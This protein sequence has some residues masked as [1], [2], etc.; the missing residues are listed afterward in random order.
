LS[1]GQ[2]R[3]LLVSAD[4]SMPGWRCLGSGRLTLAAADCRGEGEPVPVVDVIDDAIEEALRQRVEVNVIYGREQVERIT[5]L[6][7][8]LRFR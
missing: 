4:A 1:R 2:V 8:L 6:A 3:T 7:G 5:G